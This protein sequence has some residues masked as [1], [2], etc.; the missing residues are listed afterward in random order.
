MLLDIQQKI[1][2]LPIKFMALPKIYL[3]QSLYYDY[4]VGS[5]TLAISFNQVDSKIYFYYRSK[6]PIVQFVE[7][8]QDLGFA[9]N[10]HL[11]VCDMEGKCIDSIVAIFSETLWR[12]EYILGKDN[13]FK[14]AI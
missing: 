14:G 6:Q 12:T 13:I 11:L 10:K 8:F 3:D 2:E 7:Y 4:L 5:E 1:A 9:I